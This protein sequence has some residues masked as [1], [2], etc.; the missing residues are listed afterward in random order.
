M[1]QSGKNPVLDEIVRVA[2]SAT[3][4]EQKRMLYL[5]K[6]EKARSLARQLSK[7]K[8]ARKFSDKQITELIHHVRKGYGRK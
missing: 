4:A 5:L 2:E 6:V 1:F 3:K 8:P 7:R